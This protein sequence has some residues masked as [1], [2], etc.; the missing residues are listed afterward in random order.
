VHSGFP[1]NLGEPAVSATEPDRG[2]SRKRQTPG[3]RRLRSAADGSEHERK[4]RY[5]QTKATKCGGKGGRQSERL[6]VLWKPG[7]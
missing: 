3:L 6:A 5:R 2:V 7:N 1:R 4:E